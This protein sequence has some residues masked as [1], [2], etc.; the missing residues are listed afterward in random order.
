MFTAVIMLLPYGGELLAPSPIQKQLKAVRT[1][2]K[3]QRGSITKVN[4]LMLFREII[5]V[6]SE[7]HTKP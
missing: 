5:A 7:N 4:W 3:T 1:S 6:Y 2:K